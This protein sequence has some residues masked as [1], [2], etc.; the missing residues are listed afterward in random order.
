MTNGDARKERSA[1]VSLLQRLNRI[2]IAVL[3]MLVMTAAVL[4]VGV[5]LLKTAS[6]IRGFANETRKS[7]ERTEETAQ[8]ID[9]CTNPSGECFK[10][11]TSIGAREA[12]ERLRAIVETLNQNKDLILRGQA[13]DAAKLLR[14]VQLA[15]SQLNSL[16]LTNQELR[17]QIAALLAEI[18]VLR[19]IVSTPPP[20]GSTVPVTVPP[21]S[22]VTCSLLPPA[23]GVLV[24]CK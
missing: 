5:L 15:T 8:I 3:M 20:V 16:S 2:W 22:N 7:A 19:Q 10:R 18:A 4:L 24:G 6:E 12:E 17:E 21:P 1:A 13:L 14:E 9:G 23:L 11:F